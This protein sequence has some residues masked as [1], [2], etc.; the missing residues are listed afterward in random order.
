MAAVLPAR[1]TDG[2]DDGL[3]LAGAL[4]DEKMKKMDEAYD[5]SDLPKH[6]DRGELLKLVTK[7]RKEYYNKQNNQHQLL[8]L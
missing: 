3:R 6:A 2:L 7:I 4:E 1:E 5:K 8:E